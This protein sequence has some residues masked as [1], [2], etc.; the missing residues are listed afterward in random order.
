MHDIPR[1]LGAPSKDARRELHQITQERCLRSACAGTQ[2]SSSVTLRSSVVRLTRRICIWGGLLE[3]CA[4]AGGPGELEFATSIHFLRQGK[5]IPLIAAVCVL[6][7]VER[8][9]AESGSAGQ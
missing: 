9:V 8:E 5:Q 4:G 6:R 7:V 1:R 2:L 3:G